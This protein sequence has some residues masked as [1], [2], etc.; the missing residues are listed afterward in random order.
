MMS[1]SKRPTPSLYEKVPLKNKTPEALDLIRN[2]IVIY[3]VPR[4]LIRKALGFGEEGGGKKNLK[5]EEK[6]QEQQ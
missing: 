1:S 4:H 5:E 6:K 3:S 2:R